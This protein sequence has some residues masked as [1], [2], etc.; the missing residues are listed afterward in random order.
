MARGFLFFSHQSLQHPP[1]F[2]LLPRNSTSWYPN[3]VLSQAQVSKLTNLLSHPVCQPRAREQWILHIL[4][5]LSS[6]FN[7][8]T[9]ISASSWASMP[10]WTAPSRGQPPV[11]ATSFPSLSQS[12]LHSSL[13]SAWQQPA[14]SGRPR[15]HAL[16]HRHPTHRPRLPTE[17]W[18]A[19]LRSPPV[20]PSFLQPISLVSWL[21]LPLL[22]CSLPGSFLGETWNHHLTPAPPPPQAGKGE[23]KE[24][25]RSRLVGSRFNKQR[26]LH[27]R[28]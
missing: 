28:L 21:T 19:H 2:L 16:P 11:A 4:P 14:F 26:N 15:T 9:F 27:R 24:A 7:V 17:R 5:Y 22:V 8:S 12:T 18:R 3:Q 10:A 20:D 23:T 13:N 6:S 1:L 25:D